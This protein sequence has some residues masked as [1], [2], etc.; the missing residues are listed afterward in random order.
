MHRLQHELAVYAF[1][2]LQVGGEDLRP[3]SLI[4]RR[5]RMKRLLSRAKVP[6]LHLVEAFDDGQELLDAAE[7]HGLEGMVSKR[8]S[9]PFTQRAAL[10]PHTFRYA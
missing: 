1:D 10:L 6:C 3:L 5:R 4:E 7:R 2:L 8:R 9:A